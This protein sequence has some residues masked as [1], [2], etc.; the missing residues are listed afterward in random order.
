MTWPVMGPPHL[1][2]LLKGSLL[3]VLRYIVSNLCILPNSLVCDSPF[4]C[5]VVDET[6]ELVHTEMGMIWCF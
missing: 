3:K 1:L 5:K 2:F 6:V 4:F